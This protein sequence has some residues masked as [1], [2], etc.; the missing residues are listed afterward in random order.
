M[1][2]E[3]RTA[4]AWAAVKMLKAHPN[5][6]LH[7][8]VARKESVAD[9]IRT[10]PNKLCNHLIE[11][12]I[13]NKLA[14]FDDVTLVPD[15]RSVKVASSNTLPDHLQMKLWFELGVTTTVESKPRDS[16][17][18]LQ[19]Q[20]ADMLAGLVRSRYEDG[21]LADFHTLSPVLETSLR[22]FE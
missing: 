12:C 13:L 22:F 8:A 11:A 18:S 4:F 2:P 10:D 14:G 7:A 15:P 1:S 6:S 16:A 5:I 21:D 17:S 9:H 3:D 19:V 20:C